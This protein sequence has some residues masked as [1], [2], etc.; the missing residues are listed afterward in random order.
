MRD[1]KQC[2]SEGIV[3]K[4]CYSPLN[5]T[6]MGAAKCSTC[7][8]FTKMLP[9]DDCKEE[10]A[11]ETQPF[12]DQY[13]YAQANKGTEPIITAILILVLAVLGCVIYGLFSK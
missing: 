11:P 9:C 7:K 1:C 4:C 13:K 6:S 8:R 5:F 3:S 12:C 10:L 2:D